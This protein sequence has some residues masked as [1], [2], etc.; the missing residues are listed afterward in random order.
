M[1]LWV[2]SMCVKI[3][4]SLVYHTMSVWFWRSWLTII[5]QKST[6]CLILTW[7][8]SCG[9]YIVRSSFDCF[10]EQSL[11]F[12]VLLPVALKS[13]WRGKMLHRGNCDIHLSC[14][15]NFHNDKFHREHPKRNR[16]E[17]ADVCVCTLCTCEHTWEQSVKMN[18]IAL[19]LFV[20]ICFLY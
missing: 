20:L 5:M 12:P 9:L 4:Y 13:K 19:C 10:P 8:L 11:F 3:S 18:D 14:R 15:A 2:A 1:R 7:N 17:G 6:A 16:R